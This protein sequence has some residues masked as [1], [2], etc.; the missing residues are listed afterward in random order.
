MLFRK[1]ILGLSYT[2]TLI[3]Y[4]YHINL[5]PISQETWTI[6]VQRLS[7]CTEEQPSQDYLLVKLLYWLIAL[8]PWR[9][10]QVTCRDLPSVTSK[11][12]FQDHLPSKT[13]IS[14]QNAVSWQTWTMYLKSFFPRVTDEWPY[15]DN[16]LSKTIAPNQCSFSQKTWAMNVQSQVFHNVTDREPYQDNLLNKTL[17][18]QISVSLR[19]WKLKLQSSLLHCHQQIAFSRPII[20]TQWPLLPRRPE[21]WICKPKSSSMPAMN[22]LFKDHLLSINLLT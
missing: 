12:P 19:A 6:K 7:K 13:T 10:E 4:Y 9:L 21:Q 2:S 22:G 1:R 17:L 5:S 15:E 3:L 14:T 16:L 8:S 20:Y 11:W 18:I